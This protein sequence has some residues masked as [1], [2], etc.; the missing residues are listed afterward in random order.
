MPRSKSFHLGQLLGQNSTI[1]ADKLAEGAG[2]GGG[3]ITSYTDSGMVVAG[4]I[5]ATA[6]A[7]SGSDLT[8]IVKLTAG[9]TAPST[10]SAGDQWFDST[11]YPGSMKV[12][13]G[14]GWDIMSLPFTAS[15]G[16]EFFIN[17]F[18]YHVFTSSG[19][20]ST[21]HAT[22]AVDVF[23]AAGGGGGGGDNGAG[24]GAGGLI[25]S[26]N[27]SVPPGAYSILVGAGG[28][29]NL[30]DGG[31]GGSNGSNTSALGLTAI[32]GGKGGYQGV[33]GAAGGSGGGGSWNVLP[34]GAG[35]S[36]QG[37][38]GG[39]GI[40]DGTQGP[41]GG[42]G[43]AGAIGGAATSKLRPGNGGDGVDL[44]SYIGTAVGD[45]GYLCGGG[46]GG[47]DNAEH[48][49]SSIQ[50][51]EIEYGLGGAGG[52]GDVDRTRLYWGLD[53]DVN[54]GGGGAGG[55]HD[56]AVAAGTRQHGGTGGS[57]IVIIRYAL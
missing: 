45:N 36:G 40:K 39:D 6:F 24:G 26:L 20:F 13:S 48:F 50:T 15:G 23:V 8:G 53:G 44:S 41:G 14:S 37:Y 47:L 34:G 1:E 52:G 25:M 19:T 43:G 56:I 4:T 42:G 21:I 7:G 28:L 49:T 18:K 9:T 51:L 35:T 29:G 38:A 33:A 17:Q 5:S 10:P 57:G 2:G 3:G 46:A 16:S 31:G 11:L 54:T 22:K 55:S 27:L 30:G 12:W 32:G